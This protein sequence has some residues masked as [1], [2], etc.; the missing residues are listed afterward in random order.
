MDTLDWILAAV[1]AALFG[2]AG[3]FIYDI[4]G[5]VAGV[6]LAALLVW[7]AKRNRDRLRKKS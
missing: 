6:A 3:Y 2:A 5:A 7:N 1:F 4:I